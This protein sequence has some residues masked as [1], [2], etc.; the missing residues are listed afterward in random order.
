MEYKETAKV[1]FEQLGGNGNVKNVNHCATRL[2]FSLRDEAVVDD[3]TVKQI[4]GILG[5]VKKGGQ[6]QLIIGPNVSSLYDELIQL[7]SPAEAAAE[8]VKAAA[9]TDSKFKQV[10]N[11][12]FDYLSGSLTPLIPILLSA[13]LCKTIAVILGPQL[14]GW[15]TE[16]SDVFTLFTFVG[17]AGFY[18]LPV[19]VGYTAAK[20]VDASP[21][22]GMFLGAIMLHPILM[23]MASNG[24]TLSVYGLPAMTQ[25]YAS[26]IIPMIMIIWVMKYVEQFLKKYVPDVL[27]VF[28]IPLGTLLIMLPIALVVLGPLGAFLGQYICQ[29]IISVNDVAGPLGVALIG[30][31]FS[32]L[33]ITGMHPL[34]FTYLFVTFPTM[35]YD[36]F[37]LPGILCASWAATGVAIACGVKFRDPKKKSLVFG[38]IFTWFFGGVGEPLLYGLSI[39]Y[40]T[41][42]YAG[43]IAGFITGLVAGFL[44]LTGYV[45]NTS[46]GVYGIAAFIGGDT[47]NYIALGITLAVA[48]IS[49]FLCMFFMKLDQDI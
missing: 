46:N 25:N 3:A 43:V 28:L 24:K 31:T 39:P 22:I 16:T 18:F 49:G 5:V 9:S 33:V 1:I 15:V 7:F 47:S 13:S 45:L 36:N 2:R 30:G 38:Y 35:G 10:I 8:P 4:E 14:L 29:A 20:K 32:L 12:M 26:T 17:D 23:D 44:D 6:Y 37:L 42:L 41:P 27:K 40:K 11:A 34:L 48:L 19:F 21:M